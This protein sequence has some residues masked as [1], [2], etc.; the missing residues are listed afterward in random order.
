MF[1]TFWGLP[2]CEQAFFSLVSRVSPAVRG[3]PIVRA[4]ITKHV[5]SVGTAFSA[6]PTQ[7]IIRR[8]DNAYDWHRQ[9][10]QRLQG[11]RLH[12]ARE[13]TE[14]LLR[15]SLRHPGQRLQDA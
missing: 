1:R 12:H 3:Q 6:L 4:S 15:P 14:G 2:D 11:F 13:W 5:V 10:V 9:V 7:H 8:K